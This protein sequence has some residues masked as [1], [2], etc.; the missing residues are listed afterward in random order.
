MNM[1]Q[2]LHDFQQ[3]FVKKIGLNSSLISDQYW[4]RLLIEGIARTGA[5]NELLFMDLL[6]SS[7]SLL[8]NLIEEIVVTE[9]WFFRNKQSL[10]Y[11]LRQIIYTGQQRD[12]SHKPF[13]ILSAACSS[14]EEPYSMAIC[15]LENG[16][17]GRHFHIDAVDISQKAIQKAQS[18]I[19]SN[20]SFRSK[21]LGFREKY[22]E[23]YHGGY[24]LNSEE[25]LKSVKFICGNLCDSFHLHLQSK[26]DAIFCRNLLIYMNEKA[27]RDL[28]DFLSTLLDPMGMIYIGAVETQ[29]LKRFGFSSTGPNHACAFSKPNKNPTL[30]D[31]M[32]SLSNPN[33]LPSLEK[34]KKSLPS[35]LVDQA[36]KFAA[37]GKFELAIM[38]C[39]KCLSEDKTSA[40]AHYLLGIIYNALKQR[41]L[42]IEHLRKAVEYKPNYRE[43]LFSLS[44]LMAKEDDLEAEAVR[45]SVENIKKV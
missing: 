39:K 36:Q 5:P 7:D 4:N 14:G 29:V 34:A 41:D 24:R 18:A 30:L 43:A 44:L 17:L 28:C 15:L 6:N 10:D 13:K 42:A 8:Q 19:Y 2:I 27:Q 21:H 20:N 31:R 26:Y 16:F 12:L 23:E 32:L 33:K 38:E 3:V 37:Q 35:S 11:L 1:N 45:V 9:T 25:V 40:E 22:F